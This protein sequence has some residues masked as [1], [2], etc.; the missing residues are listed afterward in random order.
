MLREA[1]L[2]PLVVMFAGLIFLG[3]KWKEEH[4]KVEQ[5]EEIIEQH[6]PCTP[7]E[8]RVD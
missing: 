1:F 5:L 6:E 8:T 2:L 7:P 3:E 4:R